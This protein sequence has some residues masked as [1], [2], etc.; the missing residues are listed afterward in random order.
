MFCN[1]YIP[2][3]LNDIFFNKKEIN[4][5]IEMSKD[6]EIP[7]MIFYGPEGC[8]KKT[9]IRFFLESLYGPTINKLTSVPY[10]FNGSSNT[11]QTIQVM[12]S[13]YHIIIEPNSVNS[14]KYL[15][16]EVIKEYAKRTNIIKSNKSFKTIFINNIDNMSYFAQTS[17]RRTIEQYSEQCRFIMWSRSLSRVINPLLSRCH[18][19]PIKSPS[20]KKLMKYM[21]KV[22]NLENIKLS[23]SSINDVLTRANGNIK[24]VLWLLEFTKLEISYD[25]TYNNILKKIYH[26]IFNPDFSSLE[27]IRAD[28]YI[29]MITNIT[30]NKIIRDLLNLVIANPDLSSAQVMK[31]VK[32]ASKA[33][34]NFIRGRHEI[35]HIEPFINGVKETIFIK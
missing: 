21:L 26:N 16:Q 24:T 32:I 34:Y 6:D 14:D 10:T 11:T 29:I 3:T 4:K 31:I 25:T 20:D 19:F 7:H 30:G 28:I 27:V 2:R 15:V 17:L 5:V 22:S 23:F 9:C 33:E 8:G 12:Q 35:M 18:C 1:K 13:N